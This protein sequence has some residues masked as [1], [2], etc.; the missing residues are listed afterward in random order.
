MK[1]GG[2]RPPGDNRLLFSTSGT[3]SFICPVVGKGSGGSMAP[4]ESG[5]GGGVGP[6][7]GPDHS[8]LSRPMC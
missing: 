8:S 2:N 3:G 4:N 6:L 1:L 7:G 5:G